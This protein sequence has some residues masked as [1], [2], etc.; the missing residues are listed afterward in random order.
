MDFKEIYE[1]CEPKVYR[2]LLGLSQNADL[3]EEL[4][5]ETFYR[6]FLHINKFEGKCEI[7]TWLCQIAKNLYYKEMKRRKRFNNEQPGENMPN[8]QENPFVSLE[9]KQK[10]IEIHKILRTM[11]ENYKEVFTLHI[12]AE[13]TFQ[14]IAQI[15]DKSES[16]AKITFYRAKA[17]LIHKLEE[18]DG[19]G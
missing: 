9:N 3:A 10:A 18:K 4:T 7:T 14:E 2:F 16:W 12:F 1:N 6:A 11:N 5:E 19:N 8:L 15:Y 13:L 17:A